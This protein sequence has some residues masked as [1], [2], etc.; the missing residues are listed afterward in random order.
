MIPELPADAIRRALDAGEWNLAVEMLGEHERAVRETMA[1]Q[2]ADGG[3]RRGWLALLSAQRALLEQ[4]QGARSET[5]RSLKRL[6]KNG[7]GARA[8]LASGG[9]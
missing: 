8:Y 5:G 1:V 7:H 2:G 6:N 4:L 3:N 9:R